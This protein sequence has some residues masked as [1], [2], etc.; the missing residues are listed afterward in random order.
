MRTRQQQQH[1]PKS[2]QQ[3]KKCDSLHAAAAVGDTAA[4]RRLLAGAAAAQQLDAPGPLGRT[5]LHLAASLSHLA[6]A[7]LLLLAGADAN[8]S[9]AAS[10]ALPLHSAAEADDAAMVQLLL[11]HGADVAAWDSHGRTACHSAAASC[12]ADSAGAALLCLARRAPRLLGQRAHGVGGGTPLHLLCRLPEARCLPSLRALVSSGLLA[13]A[14]LDTANDAGQ[15]P[16]ALAAAA[17]SKTVMALLLRSGASL[18]PSSICGYVCSSRTQHSAPQHRSKQAVGSCACPLRAAA[19]G[20]H[21]GC[22]LALLRAGARASQLSCDVLEQVCQH[23]RADVASALLDAGL[24][25]SSAEAQPLL[26]A[27]VEREDE[28][29]LA[30]L[31]ANGECRCCLL[32]Q[33]IAGVT[34]RPM[35]FGKTATGA[36]EHHDVA[37]S[38]MPCPAQLFCLPALS[39]HHPCLLNP[40]GL[41]PNCPGDAPAAER[42]LHAALRPGREALLR[43]LL[44]LRAEAEKLQQPQH[45]PCDGS[46]PLDV[47]ALAERLQ[48]NPLLFAVRRSSLESMRSVLAAGCPPGVL[49]AGTGLPPLVAAASRLDAARTAVLL[50]A[51]APAGETDRQGQSALDAVLTLCTDA[52]LV[53]LGWWVGGD[54]IVLWSVSVVDGGQA[55]RCSCLHTGRLLGRTSMLL[56]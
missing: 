3:Q 53:S 52:Q 10:G 28:A 18:A 45:A 46:L 1:Q 38:V 51:G 43:R 39:F 35:A 54:G 42:L 6:A 13:A 15:T 16:L 29:L 49:P 5:P 56:P 4:L 55:C 30:A 47:A 50:Q 9:D 7:E 12:S 20:R 17:G 23:G 24:R 34:N 36:A 41:D 2:P 32:L 40:A 33:T 44:G 48:A 26:L 37:S 27:A 14:A 22:L 8:A 31:L 25:L 21:Y 11:N 19:A